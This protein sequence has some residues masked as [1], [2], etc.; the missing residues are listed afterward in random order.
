MRVASASEHKPHHINNG[1]RFSVRVGDAA[2]ELPRQT[3]NIIG[4]RPGLQVREN[5]TSAWVSWWCQ[6]L[7]L[8]FFFDETVQRTQRL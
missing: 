7:V 1:D 5:G 2:A 3:A 4:R 6:V 8:V